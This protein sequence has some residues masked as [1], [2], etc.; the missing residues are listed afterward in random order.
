LAS[1]TNKK[2]IIERFDREPLKGFVNLQTWL[3]PDSVEL[4]TLDGNVLSTPYREIKTVC[5]VQD[6]DGPTASLAR[7]IFNTRPK[8][9]GL[10]I[11]MLFRDG[12]YMDGLLANQLLSLDPYGFYV[13]PPDPS[14]NNQRVYVPRA[15]LT[16][17]KVLGLI[18]SP[19]RRR[20]RVPPSKDQITLFE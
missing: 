4:L 14:A 3:L 13:V 15:A 12:D 6:L 17:I 9:E 10:W 18:G 2:V 8:T 16:D 20:K 7:R 11:R 19:L 1:S 5:F